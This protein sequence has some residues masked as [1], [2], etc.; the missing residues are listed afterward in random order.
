MPDWSK[1]MQNASD[2]YKKSIKQLPRNRGYIRATIGIINQEA[3][4]SANVVDNKFY[5]TY[6]SSSEHLFDGKSVEK[7]YATAEEN[8][9]KT[10]GSMFFLPKE[11]SGAIL[12]NNGIVSKSFLG[13]FLFEFSAKNLDIR[14]LTINFGHSYPK[15]FKVEWN[16]GSKIYTNNKE[17]FVSEDV[18]YDVS[19]IRVTPLEME[20]GN[21]RFRIHEIIFGIAKIFT[22]S[23]VLN[24]SLKEY[25]SP[26]S[27]TLPSQDMELEVD[28]QD[29]YYS[30]DNPES[31]FSFLE[32]GQEIKVSFGLDVT[33]NNDIEWIEENT[34]FLKQWKAD[35]TKAI[36]S[37]TDRFDYTT[38]YYYRGEFKKE[39]IS[40][41]ELA[42]LVFADAGIS[43]EEYYLDPI[44]KDVLVKNPI[45]VVKHTE[46]L[47][48]IANAGRCILYQDRKKR[49]HLESTYIPQLTASSNSAEDYSDFSELLKNTAKK[50]YAICSN[51]FSTV[52]GSLFFMP[53]NKEYIINGYV[54]KAVSDENGAFA[55]TNPKILIYAEYEFT[56]YGIAIDFKNVF[57]EKFTITTYSADNVQIEKKTFSNSNLNFVTKEVF[58]KFKRMEIEFTKA[59]PNSKITIDNI[60]V[61]NV[62]DY[63]IERSCDIFENPIGER[64]NKVKTITIERNVYKEDAEVKELVSE[65][66]EMSETTMQQ[67]V[68]FGN[69]SYNLEVV[70]ENKN[71]TAEILDKSNFMAVIKFTKNT[72][73]AITFE[74]KV[75]GNQYKVTKYL[76]PTNHNDRGEEILW[77]NPLISA[78]PHASDVQKWLAKHFLGDVEYEVSWRGDPRIDAGDLMYLELKNRRT[79]ITRIY[80]N[81]LNFNGAWSSTTK[82]RK[83]VLP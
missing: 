7:V 66:I 19:W 49:F 47:Q 63:T 70:V 52:D 73:E 37:A 82:L 12:Y 36:F 28:N 11:N 50:S 5:T 43:P 48:I 32:T 46:A 30:V 38:S 45:P 57:P 44:L 60:N 1:H 18:Y 76:N 56:A 40:L 6:F 51:D 65:E 55:K 34:C 72:E 59:Y 10:D 53:K 68:E 20:L 74:Y 79:A 29:L 75:N 77:K 3:Q 81:A 23:N 64:K 27:E 22:N 35:D 61:G 80:E 67:F 62:S 41:Y 69:A 31:A 78:S 8:F 25:V 24:Y 14:G 71:I 58:R 15:T 9:S 2:A 17:M 16:T 39:K 26:I 33:G 4:K 83:E 21:T 42:E 13:G 54:S